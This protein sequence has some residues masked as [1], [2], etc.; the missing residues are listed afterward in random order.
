MRSTYSTTVRVFGALMLLAG[1]LTYTPAALA[2]TGDDRPAR[3]TGSIVY[4]PLIQAPWARL[5]GRAAS[6]RATTAGHVV[7]LRSYQVGSGGPTTLVA[8]ATVAI[9]NT[10]VFPS[11]P[12][13]P[14]SYAYYIVYTSPVVD[15]AFLDIVYG[16]DTPTVARGAVLDL[17]TLDVTG[18]D[19]L[20]PGANATVAMPTTFR[21]TRRATTTD[22]YF[23]TVYDPA[24]LA[25][26]LS[27]LDLGYLDT[28]TAGAFPPGSGYQTGVSYAWAVGVTTPDDALGY[29][30]ERRL[31]FSNIITGD[32][33]QGLRHLGQ[34]QPWS[35]LR[36]ALR[37]R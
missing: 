14:A 31:T 18:I 25:A 15:S 34:T 26:S 7:Q 37:T 36:G 11:V 23:V 21:W 19:L 20:E 2:R 17:G 32:L 33:I 28:D 12:E 8:T 35:A 5:T 22:N 27:S 16:A 10:Y 29:S 24:G 4:L 30:F 1:S 9:D 13:T 6:T 3:Q